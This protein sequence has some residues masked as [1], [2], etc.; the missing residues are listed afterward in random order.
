MKTISAKAADIERK[1]HVIDADGVVL[2]RL[3]AVIATRLRGKHK[4]EYTPHVDTGDHI[5]IVNAAKIRVTGDKINQKKYYR[6]SGY[7]G[8]IKNFR[9]KD[10]ME[11]KS[12]RVLELDVKG[13]LPKNHNG[14]Q[15]LR[16]LKVYNGP[17]HPHGAQIAGHSVSEV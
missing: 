7:V 3:A 5:V 2:G 6:H 8:N 13:M 9:L 15:M 17:E 4:P 12:D 16:R 14:R 11:N 10:L 1:W